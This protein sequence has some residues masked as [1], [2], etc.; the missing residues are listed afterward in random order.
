M[1]SDHTDQLVCS[2]GRS[3][4]FRLSGLLRGVSFLAKPEYPQYHRGILG[5]ATRGVIEAEAPANARLH[6]TGA[7]IPV[8][9]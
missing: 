1:V 6:L 5:M 3:A 4:F 9:F 8:F 7:A 2:Q